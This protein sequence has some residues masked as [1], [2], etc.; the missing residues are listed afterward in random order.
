MWIHSVNEHVEKTKPPSNLST[1][2]TQYI[3]PTFDQP[4]ILWRVDTAL[5]NSHYFGVVVSRTAPHFRLHNS[6]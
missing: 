6:M 3:S 1:P 2:E 4:I 5:V